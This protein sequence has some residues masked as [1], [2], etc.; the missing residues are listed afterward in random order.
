MFQTTNQIK[1]SVYRKWCIKYSVYRKFWFF[2]S[3]T[4]LNLNYP[5]VFSVFT[6]LEQ[7]FFWPPI[8]PVNANKHLDLEFMRLLN[9]TTS[10]WRRRPWL[11]SKSHGTMFVTIHSWIHSWIHS[12]TKLYKVVCIYIYTY[13]LVVI[14]YIESV[15]LKESQQAIFLSMIY[16]LLYIYIY[17]FYILWTYYIYI[18]THT[19]YINNRICRKLKVGRQPRHIAVGF[20]QCSESK[21]ARQ[22]PRVDQQR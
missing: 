9:V 4:K 17:I 19:L 11:K 22:L 21:E 1:Y 16:D 13:I 2:L 20:S 5:V 10:V 7:A 3:P 18:Y 6:P 15:L 14:D 8:Y 12:Y